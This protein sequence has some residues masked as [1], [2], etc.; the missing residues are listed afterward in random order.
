MALTITWCFFR[1]HTIIRPLGF[2]GVIS[3]RYINHYSWRSYLL[4][5][6]D[7]LKTI[8]V[9]S[10]SDFI[11]ENKS[12]LWYH[13]S[14]SIHI[15]SKKIYYIHSKV[16]WKKK[17]GYNKYTYFI[18]TNQNKIF[19]FKGHLTEIFLNNKPTNFFEYRKKCRS[20]N[21]C[22]IIICR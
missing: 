18:K 21:Y 22:C 16:L 11:S 14:Y 5:L 7:I 17:Y 9:L 1:M 8:S 15:L 20:I 12:F 19:V 4:L 3:K 6:N 10:F 2:T 13:V